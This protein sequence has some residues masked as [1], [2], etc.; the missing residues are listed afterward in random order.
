MT[1]NAEVE[2]LNDRKFILKQQDKSLLVRASKGAKGFVLT[3]DPPHSYDAPNNNSRRLCFE[4]KVHKKS[5][6]R[7]KLIPRNGQQ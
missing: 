2:R 4:Q 5:K 6:L 1:T 7:V 3:N